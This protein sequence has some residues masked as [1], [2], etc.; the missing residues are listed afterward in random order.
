MADPLIRLPYCVSYLEVLDLD[1]DP[2]RHVQKAPE[3]G[4]IQQ[5]VDHDPSEHRADE[6]FENVDVREDI[7]GYGYNLDGC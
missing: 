4:V 2:L 5:D 1:P 7:H 6:L 3:L